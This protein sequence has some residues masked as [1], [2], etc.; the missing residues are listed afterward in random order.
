MYKIQHCLI[1]RPSD[2]TVSEDAGIE[3][4]TIANTALA[5]RRSNHSVRSQWLPKG[6]T[7]T[8]C[9]GIYSTL[10]SV[11]PVAVL[12]VP[13]ELELLQGDVEVGVLELGGQ[14]VLLKLLKPVFLQFTSKMWSR[15]FSF[16]CLCPTY[17]TALNRIMPNFKTYLF[18]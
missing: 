17:R 10:R 15:F 13:D 14:L 16:M 18:L 6:S 3:L 4:R 8:V 5:V 12:H 11:S 1:C 7:G 9:H 2:P